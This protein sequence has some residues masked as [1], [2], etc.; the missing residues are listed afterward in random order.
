LHHGGNRVSPDELTPVSDSGEQ[1]QP[2]KMQLE[3]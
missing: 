3:V 1:G 2:T